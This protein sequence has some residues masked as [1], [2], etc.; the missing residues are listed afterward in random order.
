MVM[1]LNNENLRIILNL[2]AEKHIRED[3]A[4]KLING[5]EDKTYYPWWIYQPIYTES[6]PKVTYQTTQ[7]SEYENNTMSEVSK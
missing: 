1:G 7:T 2:Y 3:E 6:Y 5:L 4:I